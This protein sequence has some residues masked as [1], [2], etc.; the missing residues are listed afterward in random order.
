MLTV[1]AVP[2]PF[3]GHIDI[4]QRNALESWRALGSD[5]STILF[6]D[7]D[8]VAEAAAEA[9]AA[10]IPQIRRTAHG[11]PLLP[12]VMA[13][14]REH[15]GGEGL[16]CLVNADIVL[17]AAFAE[18]TATVAAATRTFL[19]IGRCVNVDVTERANPEL[20]ASLPGTPRGHDFIDY[21]LYTPD[22]FRDLPPFA[23]GRAGFDNWLV[24][25]AADEGAAVV[26]LTPFVRARHQNHDYAHVAGGAATTYGGEDAEENRRL[27]GRNLRSV[28]DASHLLAADGSV[29]RNWR[30]V[31]RAHSRYHGL[32][33]SVA[34]ARARARR[35]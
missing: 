15:A 27:A 3:R 17:P 11:A 8:G 29:R 1:F 35:A 12:D 9:G 24:W 32:R 26:D 31:G 14:A 30:A 19:A 21:F 25:R 23:I 18:A 16:L 2:K 28:F 6:G 4:I 34:T 7:E 13:Q 10:H 20:L 22:L 5:V 33:V